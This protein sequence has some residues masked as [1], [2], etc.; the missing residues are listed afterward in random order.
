[1]SRTRNRNQGKSS[2]NQFCIFG[3]TEKINLTQFNLCYI[4][5][6][7]QECSTEIENQDENLP[8]K[9][10]LDR[11]FSQKRKE[12]VNDE[13]Q[14]IRPTNNFLKLKYISVF[15]KN[16]QC[17]P[18]N[19]E[20]LFLTRQNSMDPMFPVKTTVHNVRISTM[21]C[22][23]KYQPKVALLLWQY[24][25]FEINHGPL[26]SLLFFL[27]YIISQLN[28]ISLKRDSIHLHT[29]GAK[30]IWTLGRLVMHVQ[31]LKYVCT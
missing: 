1:M 13:G 25:E 29:D 15:I 30:Q 31:K 18:A 27:K 10:V 11:I 12:V 20:R 24:N 9:C 14:Y 23:F 5:Y 2:T 7:T 26:H 4:I 3:M 16:Q 17:K 28:P 21:Y 6:I 22:I 8:A 19:L